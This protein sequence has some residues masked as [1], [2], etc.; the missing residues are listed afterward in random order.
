MDDL[1]ELN[2]KSIADKLDKVSC[3]K[4]SYAAVDLIGVLSNNV[5][6]DKRLISDW[7]DSLVVVR[8][9]KRGNFTRKIRYLTLEGIKKYLSDGKVFNR[10]AAYKYFGLPAVNLEQKKWCEIFD[11]FKHEHDDELYKTSSVLRWLFEK[12]KSTKELDTY[13]SLIDI[14]NFVEGFEISDEKIAFLKGLIKN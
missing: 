13:A 7:D 8:N 1:I 2:Y 6:R 3:I 5:E 4:N 12:R 10:D 9:V 14:V 11:K